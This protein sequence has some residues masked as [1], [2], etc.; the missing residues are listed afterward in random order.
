MMKKNS[1][2]I[3]AFRCWSCMGMMPNYESLLKGIL[4]LLYEL[5]IVRYE[6]S[7][8]SVKTVQ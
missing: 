6:K 5:V 1:T 3:K 8:L 2:G 7:D 4:L